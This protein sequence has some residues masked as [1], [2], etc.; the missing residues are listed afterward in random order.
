MIQNLVHSIGFEELYNF[1]VLV[2]NA[3]TNR[4]GVTRQKGRAGGKS[5]P[6]VARSPLAAARPTPA[7]SI[8]QLAPYNFCFGQICDPTSR[9]RE[10]VRVIFNLLHLTKCEQLRMSKVQFSLKPL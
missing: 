7:H 1:V 10:I 6:H 4:S 5:P 2:K 3:Q 9:F 8:V